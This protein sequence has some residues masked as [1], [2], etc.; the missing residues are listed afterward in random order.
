MSANILAVDDE[1]SIQK[2]MRLILKDAYDVRIA[3]TGADA[4][5]QFNEETPDLVLLDIGLPDMDGIDLLA[6]IR[7]R[8]PE[9]AVIMITAVEKMKTVVKAIRLGA[10]DYLVKPIDG[11]EL[12]LSIQNALE[13]KRLKDQIR[14]IQQ[15]NIEKYRFELIGQSPQIISLL[16]TARKVGQSPDTPVLIVGES[17]T[18]KGVLARTIHYA[19]SDLPGP[20]VTVNCTAITHELFESD[21]FGYERGAFTG[22]RADGKTG[23]FESAAGGSLLL[24]EIGAM[25]LSTQTK[26]LGVLEDRTYYRVGGN[27]PIALTSRIIAATNTE[28]ESAVEQGEFRE[29]LYYRLKVVEIRMPPLRERAD[30]IL[31]L[32]E[33]FMNQYRVKFGKG[34]REISPAARDMLSDYDWPGNVREL[35]NTIERITLLEDGTTILREHLPMLQNKG[36]GKS[37]PQAEIDSKQDDLDYEATVT[38]LIRRA[39]QR[40]RGNVQEAARILNMAPHKLRYRIKK[41][42]LSHG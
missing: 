7:N 8:A 24:D 32:A 30:D 41:Y 22:A 16:E 14:K 21:L 6:Q 13:S 19:Y 3:G 12:K 42:G 20:F 1:I 29:D 25:S 5:R 37:A 23:R 4:L 28:L 35:R 34:F 11:Q 38:A 27:R 15:P 40:S 2:A 39:L 18:G 9:V 33:Y 36:R 31:L 17:G 10:Y 26:L